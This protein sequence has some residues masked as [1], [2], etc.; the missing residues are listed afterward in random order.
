MIE[1][2]AV[3]HKLEKC[4]Y[5]KEE[6]IHHMH[7]AVAAW[8]L[9]RLPYDEA[10]ERMRSALLRFTRHHGVTGYHETITRFWLRLAADFLG[11]PDGEDLPSQV[12]ALIEC[13]GS[14]QILFDYY[15]RER[16]MSDEA[17]NAWVE[18]DLRSLDSSAQDRTRAK[19]KSNY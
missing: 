17:R 15:S 11:S 4:E 9:T 13:Y 14:K 18:P 3:V 7:L 12:N 16:V 6:F 19:K 2:E 1:I 5:G 8:Y 10:L